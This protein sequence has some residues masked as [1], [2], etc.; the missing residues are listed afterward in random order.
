MTR[1]FQTLPTNEKGEN[2]GGMVLKKNEEETKKTKEE[3]EERRA[4]LCCCRR[5]R[6]KEEQP[7]GC[8][9]ETT[10]PPQV[11]SA[12]YA[13]PAAS[14]PSLVSTFWR[15]IPPSRLLVPKRRLP[16]T[17]IIK[18]GTLTSPKYPSNLYNKYIYKRI[19]NAEPAASS[20]SRGS[21]F[22]WPIP[23]FSYLCHAPK[24]G[25]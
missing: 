2:L 23:F 9:P 25:L 1:T 14:C 22:G 13:E 21:T 3:E 4:P 10:Q 16:Q 24:K 15:P 20:P 5:G 7:L 19:R 17:K 6:E 18:V 8:F 11:G 12:A